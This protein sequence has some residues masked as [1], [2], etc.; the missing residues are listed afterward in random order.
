MIRIALADREHLLGQALSRLVGAE[1]D[2]TVTGIYVDGDDLLE[3]LQARP[4][5]VVMMDPM[6]LT[7]LGMELVR[8]VS[9][10]CPDTRVVILT[11]NQQ[12][13][14][15]FAAIRAGARGY[16]SKSADITEVL[17]ALR[18]VAFGEALISPE[19]A[20]QLL[21][22]FARLSYMETGLTGRERDILSA[23]VQGDSNR[24]IARQLGLSEKTVK[25]YVSDILSKLHVR[26]RT[27]AAVYALR[28]GLV[29]EGDWRLSIKTR[30]AA[31]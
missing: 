6:G 7:P 14:Q 17:E 16:I 10:V 28:M 3:G 18:A 27:E 21:D 29:S 19:L 9:N 2:M 12:E 24:E 15:L 8:R 23:I 26:D 13:Q 30:R 22:E 5:D 31:S 11:S 4:T 1:T 25:N 20:V